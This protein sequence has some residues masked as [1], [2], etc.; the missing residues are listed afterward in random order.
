MIEETESEDLSDSEIIIDPETSDSD[1]EVWKPDEA[2]LREWGDEV[3]R[4]SNGLMFRDG[5]LF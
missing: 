4:E 2:T 3:Y 5:F 1:H